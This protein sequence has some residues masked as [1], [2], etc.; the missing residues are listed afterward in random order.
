MI[1][2]EAPQKSGRGTEKLERT[3]LHQRVRWIYDAAKRVYHVCAAEH[4]T[5]LLKPEQFA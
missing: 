3:A 2:V 1:S 5:C 4:M